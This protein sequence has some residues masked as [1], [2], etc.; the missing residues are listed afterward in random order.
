MIDYN[1]ILLSG[2]DVKR[3]VELDSLDFEIVVS[4]KTGEISTKRVANH[5]FCKITVYESGLVLFSGS[6][7]KLHNSLNGIIAPNFD[8]NKPY[9]GFNGNQLNLSQILKVRRHLSKLFDC[10]PSQMIFQNIELGINT[11]PSF[12]P[13]LY[14]KG[15]LYHKNIMFEYRYSNNLAQ[16]IHHRYILKIYNKSH[17][18]GMSEYTLRV[19]LKI[20]KSEDLKPLDIKTFDDINHRTLSNAKNLLLEQFCKIVHYDYTIRKDQLTNRQKGL[21]RD[22]SNPRYWV[23]DLKPNRRDRHRKRLLKITQDHSDNLHQNLREDINQKC[24]TSN[25]DFE[26]QKCVTSDR[27][28]KNQKCVTSDTSSIGLT[29]TQ[30]PSKKC[31]ITNLDIS[32]QKPSSFLLSITGLKHYYKTDRKIFNKIKRDHLTEYWK[33]APHNTQLKEIY[34]NIRNKHRNGRAKKNRPSHELILNQ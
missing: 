31:P 24:V 12:D 8:K 29:I 21:L 18:Y 28:S 4:E 1:K 23:H 25:H 14:L 2:I 33:E 30:T 34:H 22:Y 15:L 20:M 26:K 9:R 32:F 10:S 19:E 16:A 3:L 7:H 27:L 6:I 5:H 13:K 11:T 17:Q